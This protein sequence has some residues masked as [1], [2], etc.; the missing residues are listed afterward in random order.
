VNGHADPEG[1]S[2]STPEHGTENGDQERSLTARAGIQGPRE[3][4]Q[5][6]SMLLNGLTAQGFVLI[7]IREETGHEPSDD[8]TPG[9][10]D[11]FTNVLPLWITV[12]A[13]LRPE[14]FPRLSGNDRLHPS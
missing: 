9:E 1:L 5:L 6:L 4:R 13:L 10:W 14:V 8:P 7:R 2:A 3:Y 11:H 12:L